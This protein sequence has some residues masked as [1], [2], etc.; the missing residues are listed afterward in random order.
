VH[1]R[2][3]SRNK[4]EGSPLFVGPITASCCIVYTQCIR[5]IVYVH[6]GLGSNEGS[7]TRLKSPPAPPTPTLLKGEGNFCLYC[8]EQELYTKPVTFSVP[9]PQV[10]YP[11]PL[12]Q[13]YCMQTTDT[14]F[15]AMCVEFTSGLQLYNM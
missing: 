9:S 15:P 4:A 2:V 13:A 6:R 5:Y 3:T 10:R 14:Q 7:Y 11:P 1:P 12:R 8:W